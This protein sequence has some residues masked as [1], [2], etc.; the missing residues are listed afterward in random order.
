MKQLLKFSFLL[1]MTMTSVLFTSC[2]GEDGEPGPQGEQ[3]VA[4]KDAAELANTTQHGNIVATFT[5]TYEGKAFTHT[6]DY[7]YA[8]IGAPY[9][10]TWSSDGETIQA[11]IERAALPESEEF[12]YI[13]NTYLYAD[14]PDVRFNL[15]T[16][17]P[18]GTNKFY[19]L[20]LSHWSITEIATS[21]Y[22]F[23]SAT[24]ALKVKYTATYPGD[25]GG[26]VTENDIKITLDVNVTLSEVLGSSPE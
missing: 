8:P 6:I 5:G 3:G 25:D 16:Y 20:N 1:A 13:Y 26:N 9:G 11:N 19:Q 10:S 24:G 7:K 14:A 23:N 18:V 4:G 12:I 15:D 21:G 17:I 22:S 2:D